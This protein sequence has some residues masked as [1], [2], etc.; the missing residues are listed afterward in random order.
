MKGTK[1]SLGSLLFSN[2]NK[3]PH[4]YFVLFNM[5]FQIAT[6]YITGREN[7][8][9]KASVFSQHLTSAKLWPILVTCKQIN[10]YF[11]SSK[12]S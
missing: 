1:I 9:P 6:I 12:S 8:P 10:K 5:S 4:K 3:F 7:G 2:Q 11:L